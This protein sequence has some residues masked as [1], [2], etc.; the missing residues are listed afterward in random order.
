MQ[1]D[2][3]TLPAASRYELLISTIAPRPIALITTLSPDGVPNAAPFSQFGFFGA[4]PPIVAVAVMPH[5]E[6]RLKD[7]A[8]NILATGEFVA[9]LV[10][11]DLAEAMNVAC[12]DAPPG[13]NELQLAGLESVASVKVA[14]PRIVGSP[15]SLECRLITT[16]S[17]GLH[18]NIVIA[19][20][21]HMHIADGVVLDVE[22][23]LIDTP[24]LGLIGAMHG[25][26]WYAKT[27]DLFA[28]DRPTWA[29]WKAEGKV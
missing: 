1:F 17:F 26:R 7:T 28:M 5:V 8:Q 6:G 14:P 29:Q 22:R 11:V 9:N 3:E 25:A 16:L 24:R 10:S 20:A 12:I 21:V 15:V 4:D 23:C 2:L 19:R 18:Q 27:T 13:V